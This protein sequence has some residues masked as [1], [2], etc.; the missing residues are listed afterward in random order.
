MSLQKELIN[1]IEKLKKARKIRK[2]ESPNYKF[3]DLYEASEEKLKPILSSCCEKIGWTRDQ[4]CSISIKFTQGNGIFIVPQVII[5][6]KGIS[7]E[8]K[9]GMY[10]DYELTN[11]D[12]ILIASIAFGHGDIT[13]RT[14]LQGHKDIET[15]DLNKLS[16]FHKQII[17]KLGVSSKNGHPQGWQLIINK[18]EMKDFGE[19]MLIARKYEC[20]QLPED[21]ELKEDLNFLLGVYRRATDNKT[22]WKNY[23]TSTLDELFGYKIKELDPEE[24]EDIEDPLNISA[25]KLTIIQPSQNKTNKKNTSVTKSNVTIK[26]FNKINEEKKRIGDLGEFIVLQYEKDRLSESP[27]LASKVEHSSVTQ[28]DGLGYDIKSFN[29]DG[30]ELFIE[31]KT[32]RQNKEADFYMTRNEREVSE[33]KCNYRVYRIYDID[34]EEGTGKLTIY[35]PPFNEDKYTLQPVGW[36]ITNLAKPK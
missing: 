11:N 8:A 18:E 16:L 26:D 17:D 13:D 3:E 33:Q 6:A 19:G 34:L 20:D 10:I 24:L 15:V 2:K 9:H 1:F 22:E 36:K 30:S 14:T 28:G 12:T 29:L 5:R 25:F 32:T 4:D 27:K 31:V 21:E 7:S 35:E 23:W